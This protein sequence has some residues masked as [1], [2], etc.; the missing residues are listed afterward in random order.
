MRHYIKAK[1]EEIR[2]LRTEFKKAEDEHWQKER[3]FRA[4]QR[5]V[6]TLADV[7]STRVSSD[8]LKRPPRV[9]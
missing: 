1:R 3:E 6:G 9:P 7:A 4:A 5:E 8:A 2:R